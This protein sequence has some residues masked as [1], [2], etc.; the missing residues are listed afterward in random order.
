MFESVADV[1]YLSSLTLQTNLT[2]WPSIYR[3]NRFLFGMK[4][5]RQKMHLR[6]GVVA[7]LV[8]IACAGLS[9][10]QF[11]SPYAP[12]NFYPWP[13]YVYPNQQQYFSGEK[14][15]S[16]PKI[17]APAGPIHNGGALASG[18]DDFFRNTAVQPEG[19]LFFG[20]FTITYSTTTKTSTQISTTTCTVSTATLTTW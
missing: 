10:A 18:Q 5:W 3:W 15:P 6:A 11:Y 12:T 1:N 16:Y 9:Q 7:T 13:S 19:R 8:L 20:G 4:M 2:P 14:P 17:Y